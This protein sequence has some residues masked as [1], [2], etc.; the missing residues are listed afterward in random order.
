[1][2]LAG[3]TDVEAGAVSFRYRDGTSATASRR[4]G[5]AS[6]SSTGS[7]GPRTTPT[8]PLTA[9][10]GRCRMRGACR[11]RIAGDND[12]GG[13]AGRV[14]AA[15]DAA[16]DGL[17]PAARASRTGEPTTAR[18]A[19]IPTLRDEDGLIVARGETVYAVLNLYP[20][21]PGHLM[22]VPVPARAPTTPT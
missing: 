19:V 21:N 16:P 3:A 8:R 6:R 5:R 17:H 14:R 15:V 10:V 22:V 1:M 7:R 18:S 4:R 11:D 12:G 13:H 2:L 20:Y 9:A